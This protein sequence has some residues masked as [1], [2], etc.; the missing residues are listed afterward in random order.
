MIGGL[1]RDVL[2]KTRE[3]V[4]VLG[5]LPVIGFLFRNT[6]EVKKK[7]NLLL[8]LTPY[9]I[10]SQDDL[11]KVFERKMQE[12]QEFIDR[13]FAFQPDWEASKDY[14]RLSGLV[15]DIRKSYILVAERERLRRDLAPRTIREHVA[16]AP[17][18]LPHTVR[19][20]GAGGSARKSSKAK[21][22][23]PKKARPKRKP[24]SKVRRGKGRADNS[25]I[26]INPVARSVNVERVE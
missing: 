6:S 24:K 5:D 21:T 25:P 20:T 2:T 13:Y 12:R 7:T 11:R 23:A 19:S 1:V 15:E 3:K 22:K 9:V 10:Q 18:E 8:I 17:L 4:P 16:S 26:R 14:S